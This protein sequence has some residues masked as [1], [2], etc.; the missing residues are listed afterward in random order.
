[1]PEN[2]YRCCFFI[3]QHIEKRKFKDIEE[4]AVEVFA[5]FLEAKNYGDDVGVFRFDIYVE[6]TINYG[7]H[8]DSIY[9]HSAHL[10]AHIEDRAFE[11]A[12]SDEKIKLLLNAAFIST[13]YLEQRV[14]LPKNFPASKIVEDLRKYLKSRFLLMKP[15]EIEK[16]IFKP[17]ETTRFNFR[18]TTTVEVENDKIHFDLNDIQD[19][20]NNGLV[21]KTFGESI[22]TIDFGFELFDFEGSFASFMKQT[23]NLRRYGTKFKNFLVVKHFDY[24]PLE[25]IWRQLTYGKKLSILKQKS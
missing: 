23:E 25:W 9:L 6:P 8:V 12:D 20:I 10:S 22:T 13:Q 15:S 5:D 7:R 4:K 24:G 11:E 3:N 17:F 16:V 2:K 18:Q 1:M 14:P 21:D 19:F